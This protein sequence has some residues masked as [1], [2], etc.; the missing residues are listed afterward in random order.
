MIPMSRIIFDISKRLIEKEVVIDNESERLYV[1]AYTQTMQP[2]IEIEVPTRFTSI[3]HQKNN[4]PNNHHYYYS[5][6][7]REGTSIG[8][9][10][11]ILEAALEGNFI[12]YY[13]MPSVSIKDLIESQYEPLKFPQDLTYSQA[14]R[15]FNTSPLDH[16]AQHQLMNTLCV[17]DL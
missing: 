5:Q 6:V 8:F 16:D 11:L 10:A 13:V 7:L 2:P 17:S 1:I 15:L 12:D 9:V 14:T 3:L 4:I